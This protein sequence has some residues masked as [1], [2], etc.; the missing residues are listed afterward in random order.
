[1]NCPGWCQEISPVQD[2]FAVPL[3]SDYIN[4]NIYI[5]KHKCDSDEVSSFQRT[6][7]RKTFA[8]AEGAR[9]GRGFAV[10]SLS[11]KRF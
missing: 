6:C 10:S 7:P 5:A 1:M 3:F 8:K 11:G 2:S 9:G 4:Y